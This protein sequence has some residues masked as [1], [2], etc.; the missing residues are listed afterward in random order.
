MN[1][2]SMNKKNAHEPLTQ[3]KGPRHYM[4]H[5]ILLINF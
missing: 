5:I 3:I 1:H 4:N 2:S